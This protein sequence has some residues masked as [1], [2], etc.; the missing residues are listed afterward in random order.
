M[1]IKL[2]SLKK[3]KAEVSIEHSELN[4]STKFVRVMLLSSIGYF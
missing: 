2:I 1:K 3:K 4:I